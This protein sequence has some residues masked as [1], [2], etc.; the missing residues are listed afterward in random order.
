MQNVDIHQASIAENAA[1]EAR[2]GHFHAPANWINDPNGFIYYNGLY[3]L[4]YQY[5]P[6]GK[7]WGT[8]HWGHTISKDLL[9]W[10][11]LPMA[12][13][14]SIYEDGN[15]CFSGSAVEE[16]GKLQLFYTGV[17]YNAVNPKNIHRPLNQD[18]V[19]SQ[20][21]ITSPDGFS[22]DNFG[23]KEV[24][25]PVGDGT[26]YD[27]RHTRDPKVWKHGDTWYMVLGTTIDDRQGKLLFY[28][29]KDLKDWKYLSSYTQDDMPMGWMWECPDIIETDGQ[30]ILVFS[31]MGYLK[32]G[33]W[34]P[35]QALS[36]PVSF[37][38]DTGQLK[39]L[40]T[41]VLMDH[42]LELYAP[43]ST[44]DADGKPVIMA[45]LRMPSDTDE[46]W[47]GMFCYPRTIRYEDGQVRYQPHPNVLNTFCI[48]ARLDS[49]DMNQPFMMKLTLQD[50]QKVSIGGLQIQYQN[51][52]LTTDRSA[53]LGHRKMEPQAEV[54]LGTP[55]TDLM[56]FGDRYAF[57]LFVNNGQAVITQFIDGLQPGTDIQD[58][59]AEVYVPEKKTV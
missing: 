4:F 16:D 47:T 32:E 29:S 25:L 11:D 52:I 40:E 10:Q 21:Q 30:Q 34:N 43:Q 13:F 50:N 37:D 3:H 42:G 20:M 58:I 15:G 9:H 51:G 24:F 36:V 38:Y 46:P 27:K 8:M 57:E 45:W 17:H 48:P 35:D 59:P 39:M 12:L 55:Q 49:L 54:F 23:G 7:Q 22:F 26:L 14:P 19:S 41:P 5:F 33:L 31:P 1:S 18:F 6:Y 44:L 2:F 53:L 28:T 56:F